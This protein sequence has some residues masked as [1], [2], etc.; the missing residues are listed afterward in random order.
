MICSVC[1][2][3]LND[4]ETYLKVCDNYLQVR[5]FAEDE[6]D[7]VFCSD[8]CLREGLS[9]EE[10]KVVSVE[11]EDEWVEPETEEGYCE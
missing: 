1:G 3:E 7:N 4:G 9:V 10:I 11:H 6:S 5:Y 2:K 8:W